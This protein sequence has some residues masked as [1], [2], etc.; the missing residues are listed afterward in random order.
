MY[1]LAVFRQLWKM[2]LFVVFSLRQSGKVLVAVPG[3][4][5]Q[6][7][8]CPLE[9]P[10]RVQ[11]P[12]YFLKTQNG[13]ESKSDTAKSAQI[14]I[15][16]WIVYL[17]LFCFLKGY[18]ETWLRLSLV[19]PL[20]PSS[21]KCCRK[22][23]GISRLHHLWFF[24]DAQFSQQPGSCSTLR[25]CW[26]CVLLVLQSYTPAAFRNVAMAL[27]S[28]DLYLWMSPTETECATR[29]AGSRVPI[30]KKMYLH[31]ITLQG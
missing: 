1:I 24:R 22:V 10:Q 21:Y 13:F 4:I 18:W 9:I 11:N 16:S 28:A 12:Q 6:E 31:L 15:L 17:P 26:C 23:M 27:T 7:E 19:L 25:F 3:L 30:C 14:I 8:L 5:P 2:F 29:C 20:C